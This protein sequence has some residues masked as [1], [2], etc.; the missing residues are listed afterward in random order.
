MGGFVIKFVKGFGGKGII[1]IMGCDGDEYIK[2]LGFCMSLESFECYLINIL[3]G[4]YLLVG[5]LDVVI[6][7][8]L[9]EFEVLLVKYFYQGVFDICIVVF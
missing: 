5:S 7:E 9:I 8:D 1:V 4:F 2:V 6:I 3:V